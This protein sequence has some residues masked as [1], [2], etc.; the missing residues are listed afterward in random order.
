MGAVF[1]K[2]FNSWQICSRRKQPQRPRIN[3]IEKS[4]I[5]RWVPFSS[6]NSRK[7]DC[8]QERERSHRTGEL[9]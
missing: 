1:K 3:V 9:Q 7:T 5:T 2:Y 8:S 6:P 4:P